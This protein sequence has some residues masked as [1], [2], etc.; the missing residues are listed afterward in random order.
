MVTWINRTGRR[1]RSRMRLKTWVRDLS[2]AP[3]TVPILLRILV[4][5][6]PM[7]CSAHF[8]ETNDVAFRQVAQRKQHNAKGPG[9]RGESL[10]VCYVFWEGP[11]EIRAAT[12]QVSAL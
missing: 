10:G 12:L 1:L 11:L 2:Y 9:C 7:D 6:L 8:E 5:S 3:S 4:F